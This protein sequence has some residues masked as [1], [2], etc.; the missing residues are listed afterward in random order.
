VE[1]ISARLGRTKGSFY[2]HYKNKDE[3]VA[4][5]YDRTFAIID[6]V[7]DR[8]QKAGNHCDRLNDAIA[9][10]VRFQLGL[11]NRSSFRT[12][13]SPDSQVFP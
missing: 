11:R 1:K 13:K 5:C 3:L 12:T 6:E 2:H 8:V 4:A 7:L 9:N 10:L